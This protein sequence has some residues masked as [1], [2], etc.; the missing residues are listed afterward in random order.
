M[1]QR[2]SILIVDDDAAVRDVIR[3]ILERDYL[4]LEASTCAEIPLLCKFPI[5]LAI[6]DYVLPDGNGFDVL[7]MIREENQMTPAIIITAHGDEE[8]VIEAMRREVVDYIKKPV[9]LK[10]LR[11]RIGEIF[12]KQKDGRD[13]EPITTREEIILDSVQEFIKKNYMKDLSLEAVS[14]MACMNRFKFCRA[15][16]KRFGQTLISYLNS[17]R[18]KKAVTILEETNKNI[19]ETAYS[20][21]YKNVSH[22][23]RLFRVRYEVSPRDYRKKLTKTSN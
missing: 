12:V 5:D 21:G 2:R 20:V 7:K 14:R 13:L 4:I 1:K 23:N 19:S 6:I 16:K 11:K 8:L 22:F 3:G 18:L 17:V 9:Q 10:Y 15:F